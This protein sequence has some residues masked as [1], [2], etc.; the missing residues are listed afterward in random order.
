MSKDGDS[1]PSRHP[2][3]EDQLGSVDG[4]PKLPKLNLWR[5]SS[6]N[7]FSIAERTKASDNKHYPIRTL[8]R[9]DPTVEDQLGSVDAPPK[10]P[11]LNPGRSSSA[12]AFSIAERTK[13][14][15]NKHYPIR[16]LDRTVP[17]GSG[18]GRE[19][20]LQDAAAQGNTEIVKVLLENGADV[21]AQGGKY[22]NALQAAAIQGKTD[23]V[24]VLLENGADI[25]AQGGGY[26]N[27]LQA[28]A[29]RGK[30]DIVKV[31]LENG[32]DINAQGGVYGNA[33]QAVAIQGKTDIVKV[34]LENGADVNAQGGVYGNAL[35]AAAAVWVNTDMVKVLLENGADVNAQ[36]G[37]YGNALQ[38]A[39]AVWGN[40][41]MVKVL[42]ENG[43]DVNAQGGDY[44][45]ALQAAVVR[46]NTDMV[47]VLLENGADINAQGGD[48]GNAL[49]TAVVRG[50]TDIVK[51][52]LE[53][54]ADANSQ[55]GRHAIAL[56]EKALKRAEGDRQAVKSD[57]MSKDS[58][59]EFDVELQ[60]LEDALL[61]SLHHEKP[62]HCTITYELVWELPS[63]LRKYFPA[64]QRLGSIL[65]L[66]GG[67][68]DAF[69]SSCKDYLENTFP[70]IGLSV[71][72][73]LEKMLLDVDTGKHW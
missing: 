31:L 39:A 66:T 70:A 24:K 8:D 4:P 7:A 63:Y 12:S 60:P 5:S 64:K 25:N 17:G 43:A 50:N 62:N 57:A 16:T 54:G 9:T 13:A 58:S 41:D 15:D 11:K 73:C 40:T 48:Y 1:F 22:R 38:A 46:G 52:L 71:L 49:Q 2:T 21:N 27:A 45:N 14:S 53:N 35:Q 3:V 72:K 37:V 18:H 55:G 6:A 56:Q 59:Q 36:G 30:T 67:T 61:E 20:P 68:V 65:T 51:V 26:G 69:G 42:L 33:L 32:A 34:L 47:K 10:L 23:I 29:V 28:A 19:H 44:G